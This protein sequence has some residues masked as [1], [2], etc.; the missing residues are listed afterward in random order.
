MSN[1]Q[2]RGKTMAQTILVEYLIEYH[3]SVM[4]KLDRRQQK[5]ELLTQV[6]YFFKAQ[7][8]TKLL[9]LKK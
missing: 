8:K 1:W 5:S 3:S 2:S 9:C 7:R 6:Y 4:I